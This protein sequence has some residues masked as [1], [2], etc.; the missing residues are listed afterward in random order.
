VG[1]TTC[2][3]V[4]TG[5]FVPTGEVLEELG[6]NLEKTVPDTVTL[7][8]SGEP[9]LHSRIDQVIAFIKRTTETKIA[10]LTNGSLFWKEEVRNR[11]S[12]AHIIMPTLSTVSEETFRLIHRPHPDLTLSM[13]IEGLT[14]LRRGYKGSLFLEVVLLAGFNDSDKEIERLKRAMGRIS[15]DKIQLNTVVRPPSDPRAISLD[16]ERLK[17]IKNFFGTEAEI[18]AHAPLKQ[19]DKQYESLTA[20]VLDMAKRRPVRAV[21]V[22][23]VLNK[24]LK[25]TEGFLKGLLMKGALSK[26]EHSGEDF[27]I[28]KIIIK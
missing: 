28:T 22:A 25:E 5:P 10:I 26:R 4:T 15:P 6:R 11:V 12:G 13:I 7:A 24:G 21:D 23:N 8:G 19:Q 18:I 14:L 17:E 9:T 2:K 3:T 16:R 1:K 20:T 27:Y